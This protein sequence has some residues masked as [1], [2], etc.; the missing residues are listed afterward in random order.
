[1]QTA[2]LG[3]SRLVYELLRAAEEGALRLS[4]EL[5][6]GSS[7][8][9]QKRNPVALEHARTRLSRAAGAAQQLAFLHH[10]IPFTDLND[11]GTDAQEPLDIL[12]T[13]FESALD[14]V[15]ACLQGAAWDEALLAARAA[16]SD[17]T[18]TELADELVRTAGLPFPEA[19]QVAA[20]LV[21]QMAER[22]RPLQQATPDDL[23]TVG[24]P[25]L[26]REA[27]E[28]ALS[29]ASFVARRSGLGG[30]APEATRA[31][32]MLLRDRLA[33]YHDVVATTAQRIDGALRTLRTPRKDVSA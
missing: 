5:V 31:H 28:D 26:R 4:D 12:L 9:P 3:A 10:N 1:V 17:T 6:Q 14:L 20:S 24:G 21:R 32:L 18:A 19:H 2:S 13:A 23:S 22:G 16:A 11:V 30:P 7:I 8:M 25:A 29:P 27:L 15:N 33:A